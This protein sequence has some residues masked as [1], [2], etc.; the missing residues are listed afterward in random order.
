MDLAGQDKME[1]VFETTRM[2]K[3]KIPDLPVKGTS[4]GTDTFLTCP[5]C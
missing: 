2:E 4:M 1:A 3:G 5:L